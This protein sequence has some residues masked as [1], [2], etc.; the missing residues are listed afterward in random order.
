MLWIWFTCNYLHVKY[1]L[2]GEVFGLEAKK[3][4]SFFFQMKMGGKFGIWS[5]KEYLQSLFSISMRLETS[6]VT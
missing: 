3:N 2:S 5:N 1:G 4:L 6:R